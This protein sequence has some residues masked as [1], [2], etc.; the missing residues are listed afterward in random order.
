MSR[1]ELRQRVL[2]VIFVLFALAGCV[3]ALRL[4][5]PVD[6]LRPTA[7]P[8]PPAVE[9]PVTVIPLDGPLSNRRAQLSGLAW[10]GENLILLPQVPRQTASQLFYL[11]K[12]AIVDFLLGV[13]PAPLLP[14]P[15]PIVGRDVTA[16][17]PG[18]DG[19]EAI[20]VDGERIYLTAEA[21]TDAGMLGYLVMGT[22][23]ADLREVRLEV[24][25]LATIPPQTS[26]RQMADEALLLADGAVLTFYELNSLLLNRRP[27]AHR[28]ATETLVALEPLPF[29]HLEYRLTDVT[30]LDAN[31]RFWAINNFYRGGMT[32]RLGPDRLAA[33]Y[34]VGPT[35]SQQEEVER[36]V[37]FEY[38]P[39]GITLVERPPIQLALL[40]DTPRNWEGIARLE[41]QQLNG[42]L[43][44]TDSA[45]L[46]ILAFV[47]MPTQ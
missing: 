6:L 35:H 44:V 37:E 2:V 38:T 26:V 43:L 31:N 16:Q 1:V 33:T 8:A 4:P 47:A 9:Q 23:P 24:A 34:G 3:P 32:I 15:I 13:N 5:A 10:Q 20:A 19:F 17:I 22:L 12:Q 36:L 45:P 18:F 30:P 7:T 27:V 46:T 41:T 28:F 40:P 42:F 21:V 14:M 39:T 25:P 11:P 29:P